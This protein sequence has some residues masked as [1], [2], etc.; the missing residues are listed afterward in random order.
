MIVHHSSSFGVDSV[1]V[2]V[3][4][5]DEDGNNLYFEEEHKL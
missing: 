2:N 4:T 3:W 5:E 1:Y